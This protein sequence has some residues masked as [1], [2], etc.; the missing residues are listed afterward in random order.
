MAS[1]PPNE[2]SALEAGFL[3]GD[4]DVRPTASTLVVADEARRIDFKA[5][6]VL[7]C[8]AE[9]AGSTVAKRH[10]FDQV[11]DGGAVSDDVLTG[12]ISTLRRSLGD[13]PRAPRYIQTVPR[14]GYRLI[15]T[16]RATSSTERSAV[17]DGG[18]AR[19]F[20]W[21]PVALLALSGMV[22]AFVAGV[23]DGRRAPQL[24]GPTIGALAVLPLA[25]FTGEAEQQHLADGMTEGVTAGLA[26][27]PGLRVISRTS[28]MRYRQTELGMPEIGRELDVDAVVEGSVQKAGD[29][30]LVTVQLIEAATDRHL[31]A[32]RFEAE[33]PDVLRL[34]SQVAAA[35][36]DQL[37]PEASTDQPMSVRVEPAAYEAYVRGR[38]LARAADEVDSLVRAIDLYDRAI[39]LSP[40]F[41]SAHEAQGE[42]WLM[43]IER[44][45][46]EPRVGFGEL[47]IR[48]ERAIGLDGGR[49]RAR[50]LLGVFDYIVDRRFDRSED[51]LRR[52]IA[53]DPN[54]VL[55]HAWLARLLTT[56]RRF[57]EALAAIHRVREID[58]EAYSRPDVAE[59]LMLMGEPELALAEVD[60]Q[61][62][63][64]PRAAALHWHR[65]RILLQ[66]E[67]TDEAVRSVL[68]GL[69]LDGTSEAEQA[70]VW[71]RYQ[72]GGIEGLFRYFL[73]QTP[74]EQLDLD[75]Y[76][77]ARSEAAEKPKVS[78]ERVSALGN[79]ELLV[80]AGEIERGLDWLEAA[81]EAREPGTVTLGT[82]AFFDTVRPHPR[83]EA[84]I[85]TLGLP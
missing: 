83:F 40:S 10:L 19:S 28:A 23:L 81:V 6:Q 11:W 32:E 38:Y 31:W 58:P 5:M 85:E 48:A 26:R 33:T 49:S 84:L 59:V 45:A 2:P 24:T 22:V 77:R 68:L 47:R 41:A 64:E 54:D 76:R 46:V 39:T 50:A 36:A 52:A 34:Q 69:E 25:N 67:R 30:I 63:V 51:R 1:P 55:A 72:V 75:A 82:Y 27:V 66:L 53:L 20:G 56:T 79:A 13:D 15:A 7:L 62:V 3:L 80:G 61:L 71:R 18:R 73:D 21:V 17:Q 4:V 42:A 29:R 16:V 57:D 43:L 60:G 12:A 65:G 74:P 35:L 9:Q 70:Q 14:V 44:G 78:P 37:R 8:L